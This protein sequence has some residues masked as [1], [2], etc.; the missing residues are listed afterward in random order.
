[1]FAHLK[2]L[3]E[4][5]L[6]SKILHQHS[7]LHASIVKFTYMTVLPLGNRPT[8][9]PAARSLLGILIK[10]ASVPIADKPGDILFDTF[11]FVLVAAVKLF[12]IQGSGNDEG[13]ALASPRFDQCHR[14]P[15]R[16]VGPSATVLSTQDE[17]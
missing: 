3:N 6:F 1:M 2:D 16:Q 15:E 9:L 10:C 7:P 13:M 5:Q 14:P 11:V 4:G 17:E 8:L 12:P